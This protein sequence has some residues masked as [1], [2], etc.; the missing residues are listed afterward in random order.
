MKKQAFDSKNQEDFDQNTEALSKA[1]FAI[2][3]DI[4]LKTTIS[5][6]SRI[7][8]IHRNTIRNRGWPAQ[9]LEAIKEQRVLEEL[10]RKLKKEKRQDPVS[11]LSEKLEK[12]RLE[13]VYWFNKYNEAEDSAKSFEL[14]LN[15]LR[16]SR[17]LYLELSDKG[18]LEITKLKQDIERL[19][20]VISILESERSEGST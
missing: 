9:R 19:K 10:S 17:D 1:L 8:G 20:G 13:V 4:K 7:S 2:A 11:V 3:S 5:E 16:D 6:L 18:K 15:N 12:S 14:R